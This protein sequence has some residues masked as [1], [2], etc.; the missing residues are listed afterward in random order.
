M[1]YEYLLS[2]N[3]P[4]GL[5]NLLGVG[6]IAISEGNLFRSLKMTVKKEEGC[7]SL[8]SVNVS[9]QLVMCFLSIVNNASGDNNKDNKMIEV[10]AIMM[11]AAIMIYH[12]MI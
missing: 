3:T 8:S 4:A 5:L 1:S 2:R 9:D 12:Y 10:M 6:D 7:V 11:I